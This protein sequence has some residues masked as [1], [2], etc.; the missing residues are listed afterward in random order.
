M[1]KYNLFLLQKQNLICIKTIHFQS[2]LHLLTII[3]GDCITFLPAKHPVR[4][5]SIKHHFQNTGY[6]Q[7]MRNI[8]GP[9][10]TLCLAWILGSHIY[11]FSTVVSLL[12]QEAGLNRLRSLEFRD[13]KLLW[14]VCL[15]EGNG[16]PGLPSRSRKH[17]DQQFLELLE[18]WGLFSPLNKLKWKRPF[19]R[20]EH[21][22]CSF[23]PS[24]F[25][26]LPLRKFE[27]P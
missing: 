22:E 25:D 24:A 16:Y 7:F 11:S 9:W 27:P 18:R 3:S 17:R 13:L 2:V 6:C 20:T 1:K 5:M 12:R 21:V 4:L 19:S 14:H 15:C 10:F 26:W 23:L 8:P